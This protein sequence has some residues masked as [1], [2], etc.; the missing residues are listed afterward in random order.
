MVSL[1]AID[2][3]K[4]YN[5]VV[6]GLITIR[7][8]LFLIH[9]CCIQKKSVSLSAHNIENI[10]DMNSMINDRPSPKSNDIA[11][12]RSDF[13]IKKDLNFKQ[14]PSKINEFNGNFN[15]EE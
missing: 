13:K 1:V 7:N 5:L 2:N 15:E 8:F 4:V 6:S 10:I 9:V 12:N 3:S 11:V 14:K